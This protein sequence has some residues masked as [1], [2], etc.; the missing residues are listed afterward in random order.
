[1][2]FRSL[3]LI[4]ILYILVSIL[5]N[6]LS[7]RESRGMTFEFLDVGQGDSILITTTA[8]KFIL[9]DGGGDYTADRLLFE[10]QRLLSGCHLDVVI[11]THE[12]ADH[13]V[14]LERILKRCTAGTYKKLYK[15][16]LLRI[17][18]LE[19]HVLWPP[20]KSYTPSD[21]N[22]TSTVI[23]ADYGFFEVLL[24]GDAGSTVL[25]SL[26]KGKLDNLIQ[27]GLDILKVSHHGSKTGLD[28]SFLRKYTPRYAVIQVGEGN[29]FGLPDEEVLDFLGG[30]GSE[31]YRTDMQGTVEI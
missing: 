28:K 16:D 25:S 9:I 21:I 27:N 23:L 14:G 31:I 19:L 12:H 5:S 22:D 4:Y 20:E 2:H 17:D 10:R 18:G 11:L 15:G 1:M 13:S 26:D 3:A 30:I 29:K 24:T 7:N 6:T 8:G